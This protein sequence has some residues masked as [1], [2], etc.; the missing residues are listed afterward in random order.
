MVGV[1]VVETKPT[2]S[3]Y[4]EE[5]ISFAE[6]AKQSGLTKEDSDKIKKSKYKKLR[7]PT[8]W[9]EYMQRVNAGDK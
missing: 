2:F 1:V 4:L 5:T 3:D 9:R 7:N 8:K 6:F